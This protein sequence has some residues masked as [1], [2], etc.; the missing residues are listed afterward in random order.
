[1]TLASPE[2]LFRPVP[3][4]EVDA[5]VKP[6]AVTLG[7][8]AV[9][10]ADIARYLDHA[11]KTDGARKNPKLF[12]E[13]YGDDAIQVLRSM[14]RERA[15]L[16]KYYVAGIAT[17]AAEDAL[18]ANG[19]DEADVELYHIAMQAEVNKVMGL[20]VPGAHETRERVVS[21][22]KQAARRASQYSQ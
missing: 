20:G 5:G 3:V 22:A 6:Y 16:R 8:R 15:E 9:A 1:M 7:E 13:R 19:M 18:S 11:A 2:R 17:L 21:R 10:L 12:A 4:I 14:L